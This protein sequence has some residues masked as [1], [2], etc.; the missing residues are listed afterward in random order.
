[1]KGS[2]DLGRWRQTGCEVRGEGNK[3]PRGP[4]VGLEWGTRGAGETW[5]EVS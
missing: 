2:W 3:G 1:M 4:S 5:V